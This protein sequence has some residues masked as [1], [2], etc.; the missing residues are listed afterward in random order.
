MVRNILIAALAL[1]QVQ[2]DK[3]VTDAEKKEFLELLVKLPT[4]GE[5]FTDE[6][7]AKAAPYTRVL[8]ALTE[9]DLGKR[10]MYPLL[11]LSSGLSARKEPRQYGLS[12]FN[13]IAHPELKLLWA[14][15]LF[16]DKSPSPEIVAFLRKALDS[17]ET[18]RELA[19][20]TGSNFEDL[21]AQVMRAYERER[22]NRVE[23]VKTHRIDAFPEYEKGGGFDYSDKTMAFAPGQRLYAVHPHKQR[24][25]LI[26]YDLEKGTKKSLVVPQP[27]GFQAEIDVLNYF[28]NP[29]LSVS[30]SG[31]VLCRW[32]IKGNGD[33]GLALL[34]K[35]EDSFAVKRVKL[36][37]ADCLASADR[38][39][40]WYL[41]QGGPRF[42][43]Y[44]IDEKLNLKR[45]GNFAGQGDHSIR[46][47]DC[48]FIADRVLHLF[49]ADILPNGS[50]LRMRCVDF[51]VRR[52]KWLH[53]RELFRLDKSVF[54]AGDSRVIQLA[55]E[56]LHYLWRIGNGVTKTVDTGLYCQAEADGKTVKVGDSEEYRAI[57]VGNRIVIC[58]TLNKTPNKV[59]F[60]VINHG[61]LGPVSEITVAKDRKDRLGTE[62]MLLYAESGRIWFVNTLARNTL[63]ELKLADPQRP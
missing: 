25:E 58:Y 47:A 31:D 37:L 21:K 55:E 11:A 20:M 59:Y 40:A 50:I 56:S 41:V 10:D 48:C 44:Q 60:R 33:H 19:S 39:G 8:L 9:K 15:V 53:S 3:P 14:V 22:L 42:T 57:G 62:Y 61:A 35:G 30:P 38:D 7:V 23:L 26:V 63:Y 27:Q 52:H 43:V 28:G 24:G 17:K 54:S 34:K 6:A 45:L 2:A 16:R 46:I 51:E 5:F 36:Y 49:W 1:A 4:K 12:H 13:K 18:S 29:V 32:D